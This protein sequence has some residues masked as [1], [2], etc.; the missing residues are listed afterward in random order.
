M[1]SRFLSG[2]TT[3]SVAAG[4]FTF[5]S[6]VFTS[7][8]ASDTVFD[9]A[10]TGSAKVT[11]G[12]AAACGSDSELAFTVENGKFEYRYLAVVSK[13]ELTHDGIFSA[14]ERYGG[15]GLGGYYTTTGKI[16]N[17]LLDADFHTTQ[18]GRVLCSYHWSLR[19]K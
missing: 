15:M 16:S 7:A 4:M 19:K 12:S 10:Y 18:T 5:C 14:K 13:F 9:G 11:S 8:L 3:R 1:K 17:G 6:A 2:L